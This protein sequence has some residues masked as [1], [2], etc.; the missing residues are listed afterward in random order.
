MAQESVRGS[1]RTYKR[2]FDKKARSRRLSA[3]DKV[4]VLLPADHNKL[5]MTWHGPFE[6][7]GPMGL[8][9][10]D[11]SV[12][13][14]TKTYHINTLRKFDER[15]QSAT[16]VLHESAFPVG[17]GVVSMEDAGGVSW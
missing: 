9:D 1:S 16:S 12:N 17:V 6:V 8:Y 2:Y 15:P 7:V 4:L 3:G 5:L 11:V 13:V 14:K 10:Y